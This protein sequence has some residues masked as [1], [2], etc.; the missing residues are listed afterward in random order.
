VPFLA[1]AFSA[2]FSFGMP[3]PPITP[4][5]GGA[6]APYVRNEDAWC[7]NDD[8][9][10]ELGDLYCTSGA[11]SPRL[12][13]TRRKPPEDEAGLQS[14]DANGELTEQELALVQSGKAY[15]E[16]GLPGRLKQ[17]FS[18]AV[19]ERQEFASGEE[20]QSYLARNNQLD[21][22]WV[23]EKAKKSACAR[24]ARKDQ[25]GREATAK[26]AA[27]DLAARFKQKHGYL[28]G[29]FPDLQSFKIP[30]NASLERQLHR[31][32][33]QCLKKLES[34]AKSARK[35]KVS[36]ARTFKQLYSISSDDNMGL[37]YKDDLN[38]SKRSGKQ[39]VRISPRAKELTSMS[40]SSSKLKRFASQQASSLSLPGRLASGTSMRNASL[41]QSRMASMSSG[42]AKA[43]QQELQ[44][45]F[46]SIEN[47]LAKI[48]ADKPLF[49]DQEPPGNSRGDTMVLAWQRPTELPRSESKIHVNHEIEKIAMEAAH[50]VDVDPDDWVSVLKAESRPRNYQQESLLPVLDEKPLQEFVKGFEEYEVHSKNWRATI[51]DRIRNRIMDTHGNHGKEASGPKDDE[52][53]QGPKPWLHKS[54]AVR[55]SLCRSRLSVAEKYIYHHLDN[56]KT[57]REAAATQDAHMN[58]S[59]IKYAKNLAAN[60]KMNVILGKEDEELDSLSRSEWRQFPFKWRELLEFR[61]HGEPPRPIELWTMLQL[62]Y[63]QFEPSSPSGHGERSPAAKLEQ[64]ENESRRIEGLFT[65]HILPNSVPQSRR[66]AKLFVSTVSREL[67][68]FQ[69]KYRRGALG[70][71]SVEENI[72]DSEAQEDSASE[73]P[74]SRSASPPRRQQTPEVQG[75]QES[76]ASSLV[77]FEGLHTATTAASSGN[78]LGST[79]GASREQLSSKLGKNTMLLTD[80]QKQRETQQTTSKTRGTPYAEKSWEVEVDPPEQIWLKHFDLTTYQLAATVIFLGHPSVF[81][82][83][84]KLCLA[85]NNIDDVHL[86]LLLDGLDGTKNLEHLDISHNRLKSA[87]GILLAQHLLSG[88]CSKLLELD[89]SNN[90]LR[91]RGTDALLEAVT[92]SKNRLLGVSIASNNVTERC[93]ERLADCVE[94]NVRVR[95][96]DF[97]ANIVGVR[98]A[99]SL[100]EALSTNA[101]LVRVDLGWCSISDKGGEGIARGL[102][103][104]VSLCW[105]N[106][107]NNRLGIQTADA[108]CQALQ[109]NPR[110]TLVILMGGNP[111]GRRASRKLIQENARESVKK[112]D[113]SNAVLSA[114]E[115]SVSGKAQTG[116]QAHAGAAADAF[117][118]E[119]ASCSYQLDLQRRAH[120]EVLRELLKRFLKDGPQSWSHADLDGRPLEMSESLCQAW[121]AAPT[122]ASDSPESHGG[123]RM[124]RTGLLR[125]NFSTCNVRV[126]AD[127]SAAVDA[128]VFDSLWKD[129]DPQKTSDEWI[130]QYILA[131]PEEF[132][133]TTLQVKSMLSVFGWSRERVAAAT[134]LFSKLVDPQRF[135]I[136]LAPLLLPHELELFEDNIG[137]RRRIDQR[138]LTGHY[139]L[140][141]SLCVDR[142]VESR[143]LSS[144]L[145][146]HS[147]DGCH[148][149]LKTCWQ[150][151]TINGKQVD[152]SAICPQDFAVPPDAFLT[153]DYVCLSGGPPAAVKEAVPIADQGIPIGHEQEELLR[154]ARLLSPAMVETLAGKL[155]AATIQDS[156]ELAL[157]V[158]FA[159]ESAMDA[160]SR[161]HQDQLQRARA[162]SRRLQQELE[163]MKAQGAS[164][165][166]IKQL[167]SQL[168]ETKRRCSAS[169]QPILLRQK[170]KELLG[171]IPGTSFDDLFAAAHPAPVQNESQGQDALQEKEPPSN[172]AASKGKAPKG[173]KK[174]KKDTDTQKDLE[175][176]P[177]DTFKVQEGNTGRALQALRS[178]LSEYWITVA[179]V[180]SAAAAMAGRAAW[181]TS[182]ICAVPE[183]CCCVCLLVYFCGIARWICWPHSSVMTPTKRRCW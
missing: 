33:R 89:I 9:L 181:E 129:I 139:D 147:S 179:Q 62:L 76:V 26:A 137:I 88:H 178:V 173:K 4:S 164:K 117:H 2:N 176:S 10:E 174:G 72:S 40:A 153:L 45:R 156:K 71:P 86:S 39:K 152:G 123:R 165:A 23:R 116:S 19:N 16:K 163:D 78:L 7:W 84:R 64:L 85:S 77:S 104:T 109:A 14:E 141:L 160:K 15:L 140:H 43:D 146:E 52:L 158:W 31:L 6:G 125:L 108:I 22:Y 132:Y 87:S 119:L 90:D 5:G 144:W 50:L 8:V 113:I 49:G 106:L 24:D 12:D 3:L 81:L 121:L 63:V 170:V 182:Y 107:A 38:Y 11:S 59:G 98:G 126:P 169:E 131:M 21:R 69:S 167:M 175:A 100:G 53:E 120:V 155:T 25:R 128:K 148:E 183:S 145:A 1:T 97:S 34:E 35:K 65:G 44:N 115:E 168:A 42:R 93:N 70:G 54:D 135:D 171:R 67:S 149:S 28:P 29:S 105:L 177:G 102:E 30:Q 46:H 47:K 18:E 82:H 91:D 36:A 172:V 61:E 143:L 122:A 133:F 101:N 111:L 110:K 124:P 142:L 99:E 32:D 161:G 58:L 73:G 51:K 92:Q 166:A 130:V 83:I 80:K 138:H 37:P 13:Y 159:E 127:D 96:L 17:A 74:S 68:K 55:K 154:K 150:N 27:A 118:P 103:S 151:V 94:T 66:D 136:V 95:K 60:V 79:G 112:I 180:L 20:F 57:A 157:A 48:N 134:A 56:M 114:A 75:Q 162:D 41:P